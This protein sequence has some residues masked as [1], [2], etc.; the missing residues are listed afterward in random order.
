MSTAAV[1]TTG[2]EQNTASP[3]FLTV[4]A[5]KPRRLEKLMLRGQTPDAQALVGREYRGMNLGLGARLLGIRKF[6]K[7]FFLKEG[8]VF[9][10]N[11]RARQNRPDE[12]WIAKL[13]GGK[14]K[15]FGFFPVLPV[16][17]EARDN[18]YLNA[19]LLDYGRGGNPRFDITGTLRDYLVRVKPGSDDLLLGKAYMAIGPLRVQLGYFLIERQQ[20]ATAQQPKG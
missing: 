10:Y 4:A 15:R 13:S 1:R 17:P 6:I 20:D 2:R 3:R 9:G 12:P 18:A 8:Q 11:V 19:L 5:L 7:G 16:D 14:K